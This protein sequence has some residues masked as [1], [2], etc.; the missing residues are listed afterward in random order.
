MLAPLIAERFE[1]RIDL[2]VDFIDGVGGAGAVDFMETGLLSRADDDIANGALEFDEAVDNGLGIGE[3]YYFAGPLYPKYR[4]HFASE[5]LIGG[6]QRDRQQQHRPD[7]EGAGDV[8]A[9]PEMLG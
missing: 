5:E 9:V 8:N 3:H 7:A 2:G 6:Q 4:A 1:N